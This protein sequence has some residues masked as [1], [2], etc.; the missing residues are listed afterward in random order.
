ML[1]IAEGETFGYTVQLTH[2]PGVREDET[3]DLMNDEV[4]I[5]LTSSQEVFQQDDDGS[6][7][8]ANV[9]FE[10]RRNHRTQLIISTNDVDDDGGYDK[11]TTSDV[12]SNFAHTETTIWAGKD[13]TN[14]PGGA[15][16]SDGTQGDTPGSCSD[17]TSTTQA[18]C[19]TAGETWIAGGMPVDSV[20]FAP[21][22][23]GGSARLH[24]QV[25][26]FAEGTVCP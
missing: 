10:Q 4:R 6:G 12:K 7:G 24:R 20:V 8:S 13:G 9:E 22:L 21:P 11:A 5:Y 14:T 1:Y 3:V 16:L 19:T 26:D 25:A 23:Q 2:K 17:G 18:A 15:G